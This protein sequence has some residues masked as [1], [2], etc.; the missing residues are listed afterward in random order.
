MNQPNHSADV[1][2]YLVANGSRIEVAGCLDNTCTL[3]QPQAIPPCGAELVVIIDGVERRR[4]ILLPE[5]I[6]S[7]SSTVQFSAIDHVRA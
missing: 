5:G 4:R 3:R 2:M 7:K 6:T 1:R